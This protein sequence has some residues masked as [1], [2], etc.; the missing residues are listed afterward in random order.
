MVPPA[1]SAA[2]SIPCHHMSIPVPL[3]IILSTDVPTQIS[4]SCSPTAHPSFSSG[5]AELHLVANCDI[6]KGDE[7]TVAY[8]DVSQHADESPVEAR[9]RRRAELARG[10]RFACVC[11]RCTSEMAGDPDA[12]DEVSSHKDESKVEA[13]VTRVEG[14]PVA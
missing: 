9:R 1:K 10:W 5:T 11:S 6:K 8:V 2:A 14:Q 3:I 12:T 13:V 7:I 4:H